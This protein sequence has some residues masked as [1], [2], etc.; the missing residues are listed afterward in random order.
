MSEII[1]SAWN[2]SLTS[3]RAKSNHYG[4]GQDQCHDAEKDDFSE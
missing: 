3:C 2:S 4:S 1:V